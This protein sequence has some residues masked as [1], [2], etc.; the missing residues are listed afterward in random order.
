VLKF[1]SGLFT[2]AIQGV[3]GLLLLDGDE[4]GMVLRDRK[5]VVCLPGCRLFRSKGK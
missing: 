5:K 2:P 1:W 4:V 3:P